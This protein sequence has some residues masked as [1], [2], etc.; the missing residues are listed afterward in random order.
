MIHIKIILYGINNHIE[1]RASRCADRQR[2]LGFVVLIECNRPWRDESWAHWEPSKAI[3]IDIKRHI[4]AQNYKL[5]PG[6]NPNWRNKE[7]K[8]SQ[9]LQQEFFAIREVGYFEQLRQRTLHNWKDISGGFHEPT[10]KRS[11]EMQ[12]FSGFYNFSFAGRGHWFWLYQ[13]V[14]V[15]GSEQL[16]EE[17]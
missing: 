4:R 5:R 3:F 12:Q 16:C 15:V 8:I 1:Y 10:K 9:P 13:L 6:P 7:R 11:W 2:M 17:S 14:H